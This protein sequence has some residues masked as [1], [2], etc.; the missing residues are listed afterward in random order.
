MPKKQ[1][2]YKI[3]PPRHDFYL[4]QNADEKKVLSQHIKYW[5]ALSDKKLSVVYGPIY[6]PK[7][8]FRMA[9]I[10]V[11]NRDEAENIAMQDPAILSGI[12]TYVL[13]PMQMGI[14][15][16]EVGYSSEPSLTDARM[17]EVS[18]D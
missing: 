7:G 14:V 8:T 6:E 18:M 16:Q 4:N 11:R 1:Y 3:Y 9:I 17:A 10:E 5:Q 2:L 12:F 13:F 15:R